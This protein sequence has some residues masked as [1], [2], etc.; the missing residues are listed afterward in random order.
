MDV[1]DARDGP[2]CYACMTEAVHNINFDLIDLYNIL[3][4]A[5]IGQRIYQFNNL[6]VNKMYFFL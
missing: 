3:T 2:K 1:H 5:I 6:I 4:V